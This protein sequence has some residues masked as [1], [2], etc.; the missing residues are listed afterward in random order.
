MTVVEG[1]G[2]GGVLGNSRNENPWWRSRDLL[3]KEI[4]MAGDRPK[5]TVHLPR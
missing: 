1:R 4:R 3:R 5:M 2:G